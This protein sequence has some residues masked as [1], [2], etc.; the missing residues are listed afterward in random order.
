MP[1]DGRVISSSGSEPMRPQLAALGLDLV[2]LPM[3]EFMKA[4]GGVRCL[5]LPLDLGP[6]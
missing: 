6:A 2:A 5:S 1:L 3:D 4:G